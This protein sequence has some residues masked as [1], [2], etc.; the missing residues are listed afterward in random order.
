MNDSARL[1]RVDFSI[2]GM[3]C[4]ACVSRLESAFNNAPGVADAS[5]N[6]T[7]ER[8]SLRVD[9]TSTTVDDLAT[10]VRKT[11]F[12]VREE[13][14]TYNV[15]GMT[16]SACS[17]RVRD[18]LLNVPGVVTA[19]VNLSSDQATVTFLAQIVDDN[20]LM[21]AVED[22]GYR[23][24]QL[25]SI[26]IE[27]DRFQ[28]RLR[29]DRR[30][31][32]IASLLT[33]PLV[34]QMF[35]QFIGW[36]EFH[37]MPA[38]EVV[39]ATPV[40]LWF[41]RRFYR[42]AYN[43]LRMGTAN[44]DVLVVLGTTAAY[45]YSWYLMISL[46]EA[47]EGELYFE[48]AAVI[49][50]LVMVGKFL[51]TK[52]KRSTTQALRQLLELRPKLAHVLVSDGRIED[53]L[54]SELQLGDVVQIHPGERM[55]ADGMIRKGLASIDESLVSGESEPVTRG[56]D[57][58]VVEGSINLDGLIEVQITALGEESTLSK[59]VHLVE[60]AQVG[61]T[62]IQRLVDRVSGIFVPIII[63]LA[64]ITLIAQF[65]VT[66]ELEFALISAV[67]V[68]VIACP[69]ALGLATPTAIM[70][71]T[72]AAARSGIL[73]ADVAAL[74]FAHRVAKVV[75]DKTG[76]LTTGSPTIQHVDVLSNSFS[77]D[78]NELL[79]LSAS[80]Q[81]ASEHPVGKAIVSEAKARGVVIE[82]V[83][84]FRSY[85]AEG[86]EGTVGK[87]HCL[88]GN[89]KL[90]RR[91]DIALPDVS[92]S[93]F[94]NQVWLVCNGTV[95]A[96]FY[97]QDSIRE[98]SKSAIT[99]LREISVAT[100]LLSGDG[101]SI[102]E[103]VAEELEI[104]EARGAQS[105]ADKADYIQNRRAMG[106]VVAMVGDGIND[107]PSLAAADVGIAMST[108]TDIAMEVAPVT[109]MRADPRL[110][111]ATLLAS[112][113]TFRKIKQNLFWAFVYNVTMVPLAMLGYLSPTI[114]GAAM[115]FSSVSVVLNSL[116]LRSWRPELS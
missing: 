5:V 2:E 112:R 62:S 93:R 49:I 8:A 86:V 103:Q 16:C 80:V 40:Q 84:A 23:L 79:A 35:A 36:E 74:E 31:V 68:L 115:A 85:V 13:S 39:L 29:D 105:P 6:L 70:T 75:F 32:L 26:D 45:L 33:L 9:P 38:G 27:E 11:G 95:V 19:D 69:C 89:A 99:K 67:S 114:A 34:L 17:N 61:K 12:D 42:A 72:G 102:T 43:A 111:A 47:A 50:T 81:A 56:A 7:L 78:A 37:L 65:A 4:S 63:C 96:A 53:R 55:P 97:L 48:A 110:V 82:S 66:T 1:Q 60:N 113:R 30:A 77:E 18:T 92:R 87:T 90:L 71:G 24:R 10:V 64:L 104:E 28:Q 94:G 109:L 88:M 15:E 51:E 108:G 100:T 3:T 91:F 83:E 52:A 57:E 44:M 25:E 101:T 20:L 116:F 14:R 41:G 21:E 73:F 54:A 76:T 58:K 106:E 107:A 46:G 59:I 98:E 22:G